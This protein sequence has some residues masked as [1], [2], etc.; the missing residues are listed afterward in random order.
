MKYEISNK[1]KSEVINS[2]IILIVIPA[3]G[4]KGGRSTLKKGKGAHMPGAHRSLKESIHKWTQNK[5]YWKK[6][7][8]KI[9]VA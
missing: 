3:S 2:E 8:K 4:G 9:I 6:K 7:K 5:F 1:K